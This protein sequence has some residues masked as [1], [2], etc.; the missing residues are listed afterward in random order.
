MFQSANGS[1]SGSPATLNSDDGLPGSGNRDVGEE[2]LARDIEGDI[3][4]RTRDKEG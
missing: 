2:S 3:A 4:G 1:W